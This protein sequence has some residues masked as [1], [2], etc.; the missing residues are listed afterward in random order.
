MPFETNQ[1][2]TRQEYYTQLHSAARNYNTKLWTIPG[3]FIVVVGFIVDQLNIDSIDKFVS[4][5]NFIVLLFGGII[6]FILL[7]QAHK[8]SFFQISIQKKINELERDLYDMPIYS[9]CDA[10]LANRIHELNQNTNNHVHFSRFRECLIRMHVSAF[11]FA[12]VYLSLLLIIFGL[13]LMLFL[14]TRS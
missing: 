12:L 14:I 2:I 13:T 8:D 5:K 3:L 4:L 1:K 9:A 10:E 7:L 11:F 6:I